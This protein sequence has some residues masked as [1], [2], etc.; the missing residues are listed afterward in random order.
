MNSGLKI[1]VSGIEMILKFKYI[2]ILKI[3]IVLRVTR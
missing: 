3:N 2:L 1:G